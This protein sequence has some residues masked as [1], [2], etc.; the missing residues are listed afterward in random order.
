[1]GCLSG[2]SVLILPFVAICPRALRLHCYNFYLTIPID[3]EADL[4]ESFE[5][6]SDVPDFD[7]LDSFD[8]LS[9]NDDSDWED[10][11]LYGLSF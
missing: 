9:D 5:G 10:P 7:D 8:I 11:L 2:L 6:Y 4:D 1:M 3:L